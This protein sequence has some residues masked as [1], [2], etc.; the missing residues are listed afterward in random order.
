MEK[1]V[2]DKAFSPRGVAI[3]GASKD[4]KKACH[5]FIRALFEMGYEPLYFVNPRGEEIYGRKSFKSVCEIEN[6]VDYAIITV[7]A[8]NVKQALIDCG[9]KRVPLVSIFS[10]GFGESGKSS[11]KFLEKDLVAV[12]R[13]YNIRFLGPN[14][15]GLYNPSKKLAFFPNFPKNNGNVG[16]ISQSGGHA[17]DLVLRGRSFG[18][19][20]SKVVSFGNGADVESIEL[21]RYLAQDEET[22]T[23]GMY[24]EGSKDPRELFWAIK[25]VAKRKPVVFWKGGRNS[26]GR[27][28]SSSHTGSMA[29]DF[30]LW[31]NALKQSGAIVVSNLFEMGDTMKLLTRQKDY[32]AGL[33]VAA[34]VCGGGSS[35]AIAD[36]CEDF[37]LS[38]P[39]FSE[40]T[41]RG[42][43]EIIPQIGT[44]IVNPVDLSY[45]L[46]VD[47]KLLFKTTK[48][49]LQDELINGVIIMTGYEV[50]TTK[51]FL[52]GFANVW[53]YYEFKDALVEIHRFGVLNFPKKPV[54]FVIPPIATPKGEAERLKFVDD[55]LS[56]GVPTFSSVEGAA[57]AFKNLY[58]YGNF[59]RRYERYS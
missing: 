13:D 37:G 59:R 35:V 51:S 20:F 31:K 52:K 19:Y 54:L 8:E 12:A 4:P 47:H 53:D 25:D 23:I 57:K 44:G 16:F 42:L 22:D 55:L 26:G 28:A 15:M 14:C 40:N 9:K 34:I 1:E 24:V 36:T 10:S 17:A 18:I 49:A 5:L 11:G 30:N 7:R 43:S 32:P 21:L 27:R 48:V 38:I 33:N 3:I 6:P 56:L 41:L 46:A 39:K 29:G 45:Y 2:F 50:L 58:Q